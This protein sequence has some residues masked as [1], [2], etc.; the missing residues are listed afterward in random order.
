MKKTMFISHGDKGGVGKS[1]TAAVMVERLLLSGVERLALVEGD[2]RNP[3]IGRR[4]KHVEELRLA[5]LPLNRPGAEAAT[6]VTDLASWIEVN[7]PDALVINLPGSAGETL[8]Q[9]SGILRGVCDGLGFRMV[10]TYSLGMT[11]ALTDGMVLSLKEGLLSHVDP[12]NRAAVYPLFSG[13][14][15]AFL[16]SR[17]KDRGL[18]LMREIEMPRFG[19]T[20]SMLK[21]LNTSGRIMELGERGAPGWLIVDRIN[22]AE[23]LHAALLALDPIMKE[24]DDEE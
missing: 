13:P 15:S 24:S 3:D 9:L 7:D 12:E 19:A 6:A 20:S 17:S 21:M 8:D 23:W 4:Y 10:A 5:H 1:M 18:Y 14:K 2:P 22:V 16:W 11:D